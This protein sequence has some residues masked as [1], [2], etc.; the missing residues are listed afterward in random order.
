[1]NSFHDTLLEELLNAEKENPTGAILF[2]N[3]ADSL[4]RA[5]FLNFRKSNIKEQGL[6]LTYLGHMVFSA[7]FESYEIALPQHFQNNQFKSRDLL[8]LERT[9]K[10]PY[11]IDKTK[12]V[13]FEK[14]LA[15]L[16][17][18]NDF[19]LDILVPL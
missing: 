7:Y 18:L 12:A 1:M 9:C 11:Y 17:K 8:I 3:E 14:E 5:L 13:F 19:D 4:K 10:L 2:S 16:L 6:R 15:V